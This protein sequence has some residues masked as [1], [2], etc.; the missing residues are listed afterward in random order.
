[1]QSALELQSKIRSSQPTIGLLATNHFWLEFLEIA[2]RAKL[3]YVILDIEHFDHGAQLIADACRMARLM[4]F[5]LLIRPTRTTT[6]AIRIAMDFGP[7]GFLLPGVDSV[8]QLDAA[9]DG[10]YLPPRGK[11]RPGGHSNYCVSG[12]TYSHFKE[13]VEDHLVVIPQIETRRG[14]EA[15]EAIASHPIVT[16]L[17]AG[18]FD[19]SA[20][21]GACGKPQHPINRAAMDQL[22]EAADRAGK[23]C[24]MIGNPQQLLAEGFRFI[25]A[26]DLTSVLTQNLTTMVHALKAKPS[27]T[28]HATSGNGEQSPYVLAVPRDSK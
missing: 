26:G 4:N 6:D 10:M 23:P 21:L 17:G 16:A 13:E 12:F 3:D 11:R 9:R 25:C 22:R 1:M 18:P 15:A 8:E 5:P 28:I 27:V 19:L 7:S 14:L 2:S 20:D 24:W